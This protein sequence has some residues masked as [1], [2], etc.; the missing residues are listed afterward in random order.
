M[1]HQPISS[2]FENLIWDWNGTLLDDVSLCVNIANDI[3]E[4]HS[5]NRLDMDGYK[6]VFGFP[7]TDYYVKIG[8]DFERESFVDI[9]KRFITNY[10]R[11]VRNCQLY[12]NATRVLNDFQT[13]GKN[14][15]ILTAG[16][17]ESVMQLL[18]YYDIQGYF[19]EVEGLD[20]YHAESKVDRGRHLIENNKIN[21]ETTVL[22]GDTIHDYEVATELDV[23]CV[24]IAS[25]H[26][27]KKR[28][29]QNVGRDVIVL[30]HIRQLS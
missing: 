9:A 11:N 26:Q 4:R 13:V 17:K 16:H 10:K 24:L 7:V 22:I 8:I 3:L 14:Q 25:G 20:N 21:K 1:N 18:D 30:D 15:F 28:L 12:E 6:D 19:D 2:Q 5:E 23:Q 29:I 27:S